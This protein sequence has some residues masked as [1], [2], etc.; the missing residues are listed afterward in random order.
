M[1]ENGYE[2]V[3]GGRRQ[4]GIDDNGNL[5]V[6]DYN[7]VRR[8]GAQSDN[9]IIG[10]AQA[11]QQRLEEGGNRADRGER[12]RRPGHRVDSD[13]ERAR[14]DLEGLPHQEWEPYLRDLFNG[15]DRRDLET[16]RQAQLQ[17]WTAAGRRQ[18]RADVRAMIE[19]ARAQG[20]LPE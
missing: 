19:W 9:D 16:M 8:R 12:E 5:V 10:Q 3:D 20:L 18:A 11:E 13:L 17:D 2:W 6:L 4:V 14:Q 1:A 15:T 7:S